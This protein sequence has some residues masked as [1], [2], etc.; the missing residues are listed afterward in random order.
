MEF[1]KPNI[2]QYVGW[3]KF[4]KPNINQ[5]VGWVETFH[6]TSLREAQH[7]SHLK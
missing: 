1:T 7:Q 5:Y 2:N 6:G 4:T 3:V